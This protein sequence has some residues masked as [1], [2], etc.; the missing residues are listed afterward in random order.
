MSRE[1]DLVTRSGFSTTSDYGVIRLCNG[2]E[3][4]LV[5]DNGWDYV[6]ASVACKSAGY[7]PYGELIQGFMCV[8]MCVHMEC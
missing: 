5:C 7:S 8:C 3:Q 2:T 1:V 4:Y 6:D